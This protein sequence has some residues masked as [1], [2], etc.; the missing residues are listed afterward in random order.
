M[1]VIPGAAVSAPGIIIM[2]LDTTFNFQ[3]PAP[4]DN[5]LTTGTGKR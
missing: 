5:L 3:H 1:L 2:W 4:A